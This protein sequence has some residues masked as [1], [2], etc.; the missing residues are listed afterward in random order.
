V[1]ER[2]QVPHIRKYSGSE[3]FQM[4]R[5]SEY[6]IALSYMDVAHAQSRNGKKEMDRI[7]WTIC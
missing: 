6:F 5:S 7:F 1:G 4:H 2:G 3:V